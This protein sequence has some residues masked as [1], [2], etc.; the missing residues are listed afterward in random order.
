[1]MSRTDSPKKVETILSDHHDWKEWIHEVQRVAITQGVWDYIDLNKTHP[2]PAPTEP[3]LD[4]I[5][6]ISV[7]ATRPDRQTIDNDSE[8]SGEDTPSS[9]TRSQ[10]TQGASSGSRGTRGAS[11]NPPQPTDDPILSRERRAWEMEMF[12]IRYR[13]WER[14]DKG[15]KVLNTYIWEHLD[16]KNRVYIRNLIEARETLIKLRSVFSMTTKQERVNLVERYRQITRIPKSANPEGWAAR[17]ESVIN[18][19]KEANLPD[20]Q[21]ERHKEDFIRTTRNI[22]PDFFQIWNSKLVDSLSGGDDLPDLSIILQRFLTF[23]KQDRLVKSKPRQPHAFGTFQGY[24]EATRQPNGDDRS[25]SGNKQ[26]SKDKKKDFKCFCG[27]PHE[28]GFKNCKYCNKSLREKD[29]KEDPEIIEKMKKLFKSRNGLK[30]AFDSVRKECD[31]EFEKRQKYAPQAQ[32]TKLVQR[33][34]DNQNEE[35]EFESGNDQDEDAD[36]EYSRDDLI[37]STKSQCPG[38]VTK[39]VNED[40]IKN[41]FVYDTGAEAHVCNNRSLFIHY[42]PQKSAVSTGNHTTQCVGV[43]DVRFYPTVPLCKEAERGIILKNVRYSPGFHSNLFSASIGRKSGVRYDDENELLYLN[44]K[45]ICRIRIDGVYYMTWS[46][47]MA[48]V[49]STRISRERSILKSTDDFWHRRFGHIGADVIKHL[50][51]STEGGKVISTNRQEGEKCEE[52]LLTTSNRQI[53][54]VSRERGKRPF[55]N[56]HLD[57]IQN[58]MGYNYDNWATHLYCDYSGFHLM[59][60]TRSKSVQ[61]DVI[62]MIKWIKNEFGVS[63]I[64]IHSDGERALGIEW[65]RFCENEA[66]QFTQTVPGHPEQN[67]F[68]ERS[69]GVITTK[70]RS[71]IIDSRLPARLWPEAFKSAVF[72]LNRTPTRRLGW[73]TPYEVAYSETNSGKVNC[74]PYIGNLYKFGSRAYVRIENIPNKAKV[75]PRSQIGYLVGYEA[76]NIWK[77]WLPTKNQVI[78]ARD[79]QF[80]ETRRYNP[81]DPFQTYEIRQEMPEQIITGNLPKLGNLEDVNIDEDVFDGLDENGNLT[82]DSNQNEPEN[83]E[84]EAGEARDASMGPNPCQSGTNKTISKETGEDRGIT[85]VSQDEGLRPTQPNADGNISHRLPNQENIVA[86]SGKLPSPPRSPHR[87]PH[88]ENP[89]ET[90]ATPSN[91]VETADQDALQSA[92]ASQP[93]NIASRDINLELSDSNVIQGPRR[94]HASQRAQEAQESHQI[95]RNNKRKRRDSIVRAMLTTETV[96]AKAFLTAALLKPQIHQSQL[97]KPP[98]NWRELK[99]HPLKNGFLKAAEIEYQEIEKRGS[100]IEADVPDKTKHQVLPLRWVFTYKTDGNGYL[101]KFKARICVRGDLQ[102]LTL[103]DTRAATLAARTFRTMMA[104][105][106]AFDLEIWQCDAIN[107]FLNSYLDETVYIQYPEGFKVPGK[108]LRLIRALYGLKRA[109]RLWQ[110]ELSEKLNQYG[111]KRADEDECLFISKGIILM[112]FVDDIITLYHRRNKQQFHRFREHFVETYEVRE[113]QKFEWFLGIRILRDRTKHKIWLIQDAYIDKIATIYNLKNHR[114]VMTPITRRYEPNPG[115]ATPREI[116]AYQKLVG[117]LQYLTVATRADASF[118]G[119]HLASFMKNPSKEHHAA[120]EDAIAY[121]YQTIYLASQYSA[122]G[123]GDDHEV[124]IAASDAAFA[125]GH[126]RKSSQGSIYKLYG[127]L[128]EWHATKQKTV[129]TST[130]EAELLSLSEAGKQIQVWNRLF[131][132]IGFNPQHQVHILCDNTQTVGLMTKDDPAPRSKLRHVDIMNHWLRQEVQNRRI[133]VKWIPTGKM[134][135]DGLTKPLTREKH[136][137]F[138]KQLGMVNIG[139][140]LRKQ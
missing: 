40:E 123:P 81:D 94:R 55:E 23:A 128:V 69:G 135:A 86:E 35:I 79:C 120:V 80:D 85:P 130:T 63:I 5:P 83:Q 107:A 54:R 65:D 16:M 53:S 51:K 104:L 100:W 131:K 4:P 108:C 115:Q 42:K 64:R 101:V 99:L 7:T 105:A 112:F 60:T 12:K 121:T 25:K 17:W 32:S 34:Q 26:D 33:G 22:S 98:D 43:G 50:E 11:P 2:K 57:L 102:K 45:P 136:R 119:S 97:P 29:W 13:T 49:W 117:S 140:L 20:V 126:D 125:D 52:C 66:I 19:C 134:P 106:A 3:T 96:M 28:W 72:I 59:I 24:S 73:K 139:H 61:F 30:K 48:K 75:Q 92:R 8:A 27:E 41:C 14:Y 111:F 95:I 82:R 110:K 44:D 21:D 78:R 67:G 116:H 113:M 109:P 62:W 10:R 6:E 39:I 84:N 124:F 46:N 89:Q 68:S 70:A 18:D 71:L 74:K 137:E 90:P 93:A 77:I 127:G 76:H 37:L 15:M 132:A 31:E 1:M 129:T 88:S 38:F 91:Q 122:P 133:S 9:N 36:T 58:N 47:N 138:I 87:L 56:L 103:E 118:A 114:K